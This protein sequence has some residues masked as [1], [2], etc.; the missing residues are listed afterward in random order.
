MREACLEIVWE[1]ESKKFHEAEET[2]LKAV[3]G[4]QQK[5]E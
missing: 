1:L 3:E 5:D 4:G 2:F